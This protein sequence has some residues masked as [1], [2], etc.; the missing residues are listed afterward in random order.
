MVVTVER[1]FVPNAEERASCLTVEREAR[2]TVLASDVE[3]ASGDWIFARDADGHA[4][5]IPRSSLSAE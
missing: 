5:Y 4:G 3:R 1:S 2:V